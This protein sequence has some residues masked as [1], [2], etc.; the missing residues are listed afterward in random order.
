M[1]KIVRSLQDLDFRKLMDVYQEG[2]KITGKE[3]Y[4]NLPE[5]LQIL[6]A[7][8]DF[9]TYLQTFFKEPTAR[10]AVWVVNGRYVSALRYES[11]NDGL[12]VN[13]L[14]TMPT[15]RNRGFATLLIRSVQDFLRSQGNG[16]LYSHISKDN[17]TSVK[18]H[19]SSGFQI[20]S[21]E[22]TY[23]DGAV[24]SDSY[25]LSVEY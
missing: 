8:Q 19:L 24:R 10:Y 4:P 22:A 18:V 5:N 2:N 20:I 23:L 13:A 17:M 12:L 1:L 15:E 3:V 9:Y 11:Y 25:T 21:H 7:E 6:Y 16:I 14:E